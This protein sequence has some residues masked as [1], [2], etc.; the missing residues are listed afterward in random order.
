MAGW[1]F[2]VGVRAD[3]AVRYLWLNVLW[4][5]LT[6][7]IVGAPTATVAL[8]AVVAEWARGD[9]RGVA[10]RYAAAVRAH[11]R[12][13][14]VAGALVA[15]IGCL[16]ILNV[17]VALHMGGIQRPLVLGLLGAVA[18]TLTLLGTSVPPAVV[19]GASNIR[20][21]ARETARLVATR[22]VG[23]VVAVAA[24][25]SII[26]AALAF[27]PALLI[28][29]SPAARLVHALRSGRR[30]TFTLPRTRMERTYA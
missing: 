8:H 14:S 18:T 15:A 17:Y 4:L 11:W 26:G 23:A 22:P 3:E 24:A 25:A 7:T 2:G 28:L 16:L 9:G 21:L 1:T 5:A 20:T 27:P 6:L 19:A 12:D 29:P 30:P 10:V 13:A